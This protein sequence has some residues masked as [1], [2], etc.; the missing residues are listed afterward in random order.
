MASP[1]QEMLSQAPEI[2]E[3]WQI[4][5]SGC[6]LQRSF[7]F[8]GSFESGLPSSPAALLVVAVV[9]DVVSVPSGWVIV[10]V[11]VVD[12]LPSLFC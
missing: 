1:V 8:S 9:L 6:C 12:V 4:F 3:F 7:G 2:L 10:V 5:N 11:V